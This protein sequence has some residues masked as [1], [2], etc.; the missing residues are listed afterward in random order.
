MRMTRT[1]VVIG[2]VVVVLAAVA[3]AVA[4]VLGTGDDGA[5]AGGSTTSPTST[6][7]PLVT[8]PEIAP[9]DRARYRK[10]FKSMK[11]GTTRIEILSKWPKPYQDFPD[12]FGDR[13]VEWKMGRILYDLCFKK[14]VLVLKD[15][16]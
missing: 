4:I 6:D 8:R 7:A 9:T 10:L 11:V 14:D 1:R 16:G 13:C 2:A 12:Q 15:P 5:K 3:L